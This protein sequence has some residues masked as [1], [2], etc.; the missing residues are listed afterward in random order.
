MILNMAAE[1][2]AAAAEETM[3][4]VPGKGEKMPEKEKELAEDASEES[5]FNFQNII[6]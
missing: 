5:V 4:T 2:I 1:E 6:G 3:A